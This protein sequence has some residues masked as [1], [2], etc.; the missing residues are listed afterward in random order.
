MLKR[1][2]LLCINCSHSYA[3]LLEST[4][5]INHY[6]QVEK[7]DSSVV[8]DKLNKGNQFTC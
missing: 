1:Y 5:K 7:V 3:H 2:T 6:Q 8:T 4:V